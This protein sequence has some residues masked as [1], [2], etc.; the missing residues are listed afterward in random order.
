[1]GNMQSESG[2]DPR[3]LQPGTTGDAPI[4]GRG[5]GLVQWTFEERQKP[6]E[7]RAKAAGVPVYDLG[8]QLDYVMYELDEKM[9]DIGKQLRATTDVKSATL[10]I[11][12]KYEIHKGGIQPERQSQAE[13]FLAQFGSNAGTAGAS[14]G[15]SCTT[16]SAGQVVGSFSLPVDIRCSGHKP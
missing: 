2:L 3:A 15:T 7:D 14:G 6:L 16:N 4:R 1:M 13:T 12:T 10:L 11:E 9:P 8:L 5:Y